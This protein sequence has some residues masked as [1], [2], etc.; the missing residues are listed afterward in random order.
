[1][2]T[3]NQTKTG[4]AQYPERDRVSDEDGSSTDE[5]APGKPAVPVAAEERQNEERGNRGPE[6]QPGFGQGA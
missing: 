2:N 4:T 6:R 1:M 3:P 5:T